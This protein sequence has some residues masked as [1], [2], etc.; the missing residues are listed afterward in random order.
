MKLPSP[1]K[2]LKLIYNEMKLSDP[3]NV[4]HIIP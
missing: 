4:F 1:T 2:K 3:N